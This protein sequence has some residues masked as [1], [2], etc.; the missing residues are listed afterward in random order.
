MIARNTSFAKISLTTSLLKSTLKITLREPRRRADRRNAN[1]FLQ[2]THYVISAE[3]DTRE[4]TTPK[5]RLPDT[6]ALL[7]YTHYVISVEDYTKEDATPQ[8]KLNL[9]YALYPAFLGTR[10]NV[11]LNFGGSRVHGKWFV[12]ENG[13]GNCFRGRL[14]LPW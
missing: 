11:I 8:S 2:N 7:Q 12:G 3:Y 10:P 14:L 4:D 1:S 9:F 6:N 13:S 5:G